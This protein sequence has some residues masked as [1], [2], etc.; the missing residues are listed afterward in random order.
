MQSHVIFTDEELDIIVSFFNSNYG[1]VTW[2]RSGSDVYVVG[3][4]PVPVANR[5]LEV[6][7]ARFYASRACKCSA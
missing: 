2:M 4:L 5:A 6:I 3:D 1:L 7:W